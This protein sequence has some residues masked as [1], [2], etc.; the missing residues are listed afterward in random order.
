MPAPITKAH[1][2]L[3][4]AL[5]EYTKLSAHADTL[6]GEELQPVLL[7][8]AAAAVG[9]LEYIK[10]ASVITGVKDVLTSPA[11]KE[12][13]R[14]ALTGAAVAGGAAVPAVV[15]GNMI[16]DRATENA[17]NRALQ[18]GAGLM[19]MGATMYGLHHLANGQKQASAVDE[20]FHKLAAVGYV[21]EQLDGMLEDPAATP[22]EK[23]LA[24]ELKCLNAEYGVELFRSLT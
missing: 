19:G 20:T 18:T 12:M 22:E 21:D 2:E 5:A 10:T 14:K 15:A 8:K 11:A 6:S 1:F 13:G 7:Q 17:R 4:T 3:G 23:K 9:I 24:A 16:S